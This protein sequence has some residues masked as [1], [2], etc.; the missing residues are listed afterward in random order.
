ML[1]T[2]CRDL[3][4]AGALSSVPALSAS[5][6][7]KTATGANSGID[8]LA[9]RVPLNV[10]SA[11]PSP[12]AEDAAPFQ[13][14]AL[15]AANRKAAGILEL[16]A[17]RSNATANETQRVMVRERLA[18]DDKPPQLA[19]K[20]SSSKPSNDGFETDEDGNLRLRILHFND[21]H[22]RMEPNSDSAHALCDEWRIKNG[23]C[24]FCYSVLQ[25]SLAAT[26]I[27]VL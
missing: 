26:I 6:P 13:A 25:N 14:A 4:A 7:G 21:W 19:A 15:I 10:G 12:D 16:D 18:R 20:E 3:C 5:S 22:N 1:S 11:S 27:T 2:L 24:A 8:N 23:G 17:L 9:S